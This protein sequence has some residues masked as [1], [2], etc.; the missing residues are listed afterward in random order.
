MRLWILLAL[1]MVG[2]AGCAPRESLVALEEPKIVLPPPPTPWVVVPVT[3]PP[4]A[5][6]VVRRPDPPPTSPSLLDPM[7]PC[8]P[9][10]PASRA[11]TT[12]SLDR[13]QLVAEVRWAKQRAELCCPKVTGS[14]QVAV[15]V[16]PS[17]APS[18]VTVAPPSGAAPGAGVCVKR[19]FAEIQVTPWS[20]A[21]VT[22]KS[23][24]STAMSAALG[25]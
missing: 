11:S 4:I 9:R 18:A 7:D 23:D 1:A 2:L 22:E 24:V 8:L 14:I 10:A 15:T 3:M 21:A 12:A 17:G 6:V 13:S 16:A 25:P 20:G 19:L 5:V